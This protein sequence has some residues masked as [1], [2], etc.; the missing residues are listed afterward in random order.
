MRVKGFYTEKTEENR[1]TQR[2]MKAKPRK[3]EFHSSGFVA[4]LLFAFSIAVSAG[5]ASAAAKDKS[6][7]SGAGSLLLRMG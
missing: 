1:S 3:S 7:R 6:L 5:V 2:K 4:A